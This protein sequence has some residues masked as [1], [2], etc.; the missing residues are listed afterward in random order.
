MVSCQSNSRWTHNR[1]LCHTDF[2]HFSPHHPLPFSENKPGKGR[3]FTAQIGA[4]CANGPSIDA[5][6]SLLL[7]VRNSQQGEVLVG[8]L[9]PQHTL[10]QP[11]NTSSTTWLQNEQGKNSEHRRK[12]VLSCNGVQKTRGKQPWKKAAD[13]AGHVQAIALP[14]CSQTLFQIAKPQMP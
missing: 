12:S 2:V 7:F 3:H 13:S 1:R 9:L 8:Q 11:S 4:I 6:S 10:P 5:S 14:K